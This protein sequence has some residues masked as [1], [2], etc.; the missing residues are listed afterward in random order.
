MLWLVLTTRGASQVN[1]ERH[2]GKFATC[3][4]SAERTT[5]VAEVLVGS[6]VELRGN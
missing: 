6:S 1:P 3:W 4:L 2:A 5:V